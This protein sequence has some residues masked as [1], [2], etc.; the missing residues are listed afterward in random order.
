MSR[1]SGPQNRGASRR[2]HD[3]RRTEAETRQ[4]EERAWLQEHTRKIE[5]DAAN[6]KPLTDDDLAELLL[7]ALAAEPSRALIELLLKDQV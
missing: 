7:A 3:Q 1:F 5:A 6:A 4:A 2:L